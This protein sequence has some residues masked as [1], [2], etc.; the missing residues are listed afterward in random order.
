MRTVDAAS[1]DRDRRA[2]PTDAGLCS[3]GFDNGEGP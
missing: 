3:A 1:L 2:G